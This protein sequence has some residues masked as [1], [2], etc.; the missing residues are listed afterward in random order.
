MKVDA[1]IQAIKRFGLSALR[2]AGAF[3]LVRDSSWRRQRLVILYYHGISLHRE[4]RWRPL[5][6]VSQ[7][8]SR[9]RLELLCDGGFNV[10]PLGES[11]RKLVDGSLPE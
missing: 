3:Q 1:T 9:R 7:D 10:L 2:K 4:H 5:L 8:F 6:Y 11:M